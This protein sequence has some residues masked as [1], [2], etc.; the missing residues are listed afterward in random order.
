MELPY[1]P[2]V[3]MGAGYDHIKRRFRANAFE[4]SHKMK[5]EKLEMANHQSHRDI[6]ED[7]EFLGSKLR[8]HTQT[9]E[10]NGWTILQTAEEYWAKSEDFKTG[11]V[12]F[13]L[14]KSSTYLEEEFENYP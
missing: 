1:D 4:D 7:P 13:T 11:D 3:R 8:Q 2:L 12:L 6:I 10:E 14:E 9:I 5:L